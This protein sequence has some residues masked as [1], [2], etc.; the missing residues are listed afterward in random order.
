MT[1]SPTITLPAGA[2]ANAGRVGFQFI[3]RHFDEARLVNA[4]DAFQ[5]HTDWHKQY[6]SL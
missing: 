2:T 3:G 6:P 1:G 5:R 4:G